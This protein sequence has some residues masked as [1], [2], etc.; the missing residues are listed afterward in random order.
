MRETIEFR[1]EEKDAQ[2]YLRP[3][4]GEVI[5]PGG[6]VRKLVVDSSDSR[7]ETIRK[8]EHQFRQRGTFFFSSWNIHRQYT[9]KELEN[10]ELLH[11][12]L[13]TAFEPPGECCGTE[14]DDAAACP[15]CGAGARQLNELRLE[16]SSLPRGK[17]LART[18]AWNEL[19]VSA[20]LAEAMRAHALSGARFLPVVRKSGR[21]PLDGWFQLEVTSRPLGVGP[22]T[23]FGQDPF[24]LDEKGE[25][26]CP[27]GHTAGLNI[28]SELSVLRGEWDGADLCATR[29]LLGY[30]SRNGGVLRPYPMLLIS[31]RLRRV[32]VELK[33]KG[34]D[35]EV[36]HLV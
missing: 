27:Q 18:I 13:R 26:R 5:G 21:G 36:A 17:D 20:R 7:V 6:D 1:I 35:L 3:E 9:P 28:L 23:R 16:P 2:R 33:A 22:A 24:D 10:A 34:F 30:R 8:L 32:L 25:Y 15:N 19:L 29:Q 31:Q 12:R 14:Y 11:L 4:D